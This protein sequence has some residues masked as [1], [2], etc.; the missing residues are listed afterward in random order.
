MKIKNILIVPMFLL[1]GMLLITNVKAAGFNVSRSITGVKN[2]V[3]NTFTYRVTASSSNPGASTS[4]VTPPADTTI[5]FTSSNSVSGTTV[6]VNSTPL[7]AESVWLGLSYP[8]PG[9]YTFVVSEYS[10]SNATQYPR[11]TKTYDV[12]I[13]V[14]NVTDSNNMPTGD[15]NVQYVFARQTGTT[16][17][18]GKKDKNQ[19]VTFTS[20]ANM[21]NIKVASLVTGNNSNANEYFKYTVTITNNVGGTTY[22][23]VGQ[24]T[25]VTW[26]GGSVNTSSSCT[27]GTCTIYL[28][29]GQ[30]A[31]IGAQTLNHIPQGLTYSVVQNNTTDQSN[32]YSSTSYKIGPTN[33]PVASGTGTTT[34][35]RTVNATAAN[36]V[37]TFTNHSETSSPTGLIVKL[38][39]FVLLLVL[40]VVGIV[41]IK[42]TKKIEA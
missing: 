12:V 7:I 10:S 27:T 11:D 2:T 13:Y 37:V 42:N 34:G 29:H 4:P 41:L 14:T 19:N 30:S 35:N 33:N 32:I 40:S 6:T 8:Q 18:S 20:A 24:D 23:V 39:P 5:Q 25:T 17:T 21:S 16:G 22:S 28:K 15:M 3:T 38:F 36:N 26:N 1:L 31:E 9:T